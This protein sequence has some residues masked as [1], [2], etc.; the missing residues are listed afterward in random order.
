MD[1][2]GHRT[3]VAHDSGCWVSGVLPHAPKVALSFANRIKVLLLW[4][5]PPEVCSV[6]CLAFYNVSRSRVVP[7][8]LLGLFAR[9]LPY[10][11]KVYWRSAKLRVEGCPGG[12][13]R[14]Q[15][16]SPR[17]SFL[18]LPGNVR[19]YYVSTHEVDGLFELP[20]ENE[21]Y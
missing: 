4:S 15:H 14:C 17:S 18:C 12:P 21:W 16:E 13:F 5:S 9:F 7:M 3:G 8:V 6:P 10:R 11:R 20:G 1:D 19:L 2:H